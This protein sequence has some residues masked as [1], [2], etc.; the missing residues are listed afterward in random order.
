MRLGSGKGGGPLRS[1]ARDNVSRA[2]T[3]VEDIVYVG[4]GLLLSGAALVLLVSLGFTF[5]RGLMAGA[6][7]GSVIVVLDQILLILMIVEL[8]YTVQLSFREHVL[9]P[10]PFVLVALIAGVRRVLVLAPE[11]PKVLEK[12]DAQF[13]NAMIELAVLTVMTLSLVFCL[14]LLRKR[15]PD[16]VAERV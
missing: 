14:V 2:F 15:H 5:W 4:L 9:V 12:G 8:L 1:S 3:M 11:L 13:Q 16:A 7:P 6:L 10:E